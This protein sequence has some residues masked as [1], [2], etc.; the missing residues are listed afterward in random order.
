[1]SWN[2]PFSCPFSRHPV[3]VTEAAFADAAIAI[4]KSPLTTIV[5]NCSPRIPISFFR[6]AV[7][8]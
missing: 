6:G 7:R 8:L 5:E 2:S 4:A 1:V 3:T